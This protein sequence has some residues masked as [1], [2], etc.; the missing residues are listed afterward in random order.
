MLVRQRFVRFQLEHIQFCFK[1]VIIQ[2]QA[3]IRLKLVIKQPILV[4]KQPKL[5]IRQPILVIKQPILV[6]KQP[7]QAVRSLVDEQ[8]I[9]QLLNIQFFLRFFLTRCN[10]QLFSLIKY[11]QLLFFLEE[12]IQ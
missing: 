11:I 10:L 6:I 12:H 7:I 2:Q 3:T 9:F 5:V 4:I 1:L 8:L